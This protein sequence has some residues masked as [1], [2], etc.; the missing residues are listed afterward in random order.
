MNYTAAVLTI[1]DKGSIGERE[2][3]SGPALCKMLEEAGYQIAEKDILPDDYDKI[4]EKL[5]EFTDLKGYALILT[6][7]GTG[8][9]KRDVTPEATLS[10]LEKEAR[11]I[12]EAMRYASLQITPRACLSREVAGIRCESLII[13]LPGSKKASTENLA[14]VLDSLGHGLD[15]LKG[16]THDCGEEHHHG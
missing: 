11:G 10:V 13:N 4:R 2:D 5:I 14:A 3:T 6:T 12:P 1:S 15:V 9:S 16:N 8:F 7:G